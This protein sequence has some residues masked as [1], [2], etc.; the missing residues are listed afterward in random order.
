LEVDMLANVAVGFGLS[1]ALGFE[2]QLRG[3]VAGDRTFALVGTSAAAIT[4]VTHTTSPQAIA[5]IVTGIGFIGGGVVFKL[6]TGSVHGVTT[7]A[8]ILA[9]AA[10]GIVAGYGDLLLALILTA[11]MLLLLEIPQIPLLRFVDARTYMGRTR[12]DPDLVVPDPSSEADLANPGASRG[13][14]TARP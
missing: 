10:I 12:R 14:G 4:V 9:A 13:D 7:A 1:Y 6:R 8:T 3:S 2:R 5:G 11:V